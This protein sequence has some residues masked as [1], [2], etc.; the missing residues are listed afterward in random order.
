MPLGI[1]KLAHHRVIA[2][3]L[4]CFLVIYVILEVICNFAC[5][6]KVRFIGAEKKDHFF[7][8]LPLLE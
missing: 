3:Y 4:P 5:A 1:Q 8:R 2:M 6:K 7:D